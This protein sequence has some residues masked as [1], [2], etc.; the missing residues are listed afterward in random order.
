M[1]LYGQLCRADRKKKKNRFIDDPPYLEL[2]SP[3]RVLGGDGEVIF[4]ASINSKA[5]KNMEIKKASHY[6]VVFFH[7]EKGPSLCPTTLL[8]LFVPAQM[9]KQ[10]LLNG[11]PDHDAAVCSLLKGDSQAEVLDTSEEALDEETGK[12]L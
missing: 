7:E 1:V 10:L 9:S 8:I 6:A 5:R 2:M 11:D 3:V 12:L 4:F